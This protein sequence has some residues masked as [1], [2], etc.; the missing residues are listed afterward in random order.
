MIRDWGFTGTIDFISSLLKIGSVY[1]LLGVSSVLSVLEL[2]T[3]LNALSLVLALIMMIIELVTGIWA[4]RKRKEKIESRRAGRFLLKIF[5]YSFFIMLFNVFSIQYK[6]GIRHLAFEWLHSF[7]LF[8]IIGIYSI[9]IFENFGFII[10]RKKE[11]HPIIEAIKK[12]LLG[13][14]KEKND[15]Q[16]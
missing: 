4:S 1:K 2:L 7:T 5:I 8:Y 14:S 11:F 12:K 15:G 13:D 6:E 16:E 9:S 10:D 3:G